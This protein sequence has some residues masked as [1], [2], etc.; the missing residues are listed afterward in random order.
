MEKVHPLFTLLSLLF[1]IL[2]YLIPL[3]L[4]QQAH[5]MLAVM[6]FVVAL[7]ISE[8]AQLHATAIFAAF[9]LVTVVGLPANE[10]FALYFDPVIVLL[11]GGFVIAVAMQH[12]KLDEYLAHSIMSRAGTNP[13]T[14]VFALIGATA[15]ISMW[16]NNSSAA[17]IVMPIALVILARN[18]V[19]KGISNFGKACVLAVGY[20]ATIG[21]IG[22]IVGSTPN[23]MAAKF[24]HDQGVQ[25][26]FYEWFIRGFPLMVLL[27]IAGWVV[28]V[29]LFKPEKK[30]IIPI[31]KVMRMNLSQKKVL[32]IFALTI[33]LWITES[34]HGISSAVIALVP[35]VLF[36]FT[37]ILTTD[38]FLKVDWPTLILIGGGLALGFGIHTTGLDIALASLLSSAAIGQNLLGVFLLLGLFG[39]LLTVFISNTTA[40]AVYLPIVVAL[41]SALGGSITNVVVVAAIGVSLDFIFPFG[42]PPTAIALGTG[43]VRQKD[44]AKAGIIISIIG[45]ILLGLMAMIW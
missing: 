22:T 17:A 33:V 6:V 24:L 35:I 7:W 31:R 19:K 10:V 11:L 41:A 40:A 13:R 16:I 34:I 5:V 37:G 44:I 36:Y 32:V 20:G 12:H 3:G 38:D 45:I 27:V 29:T 30:K 42:T 26:G 9:L 39:V 8:A 15:V 14:V 4:S 43:Y 21:G 2:A 18:R 25:F 28:L 1:A 23:I